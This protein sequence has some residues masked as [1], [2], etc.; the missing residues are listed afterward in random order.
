MWY[1]LPYLY[2]VQYNKVKYIPLFPKSSWRVP[3]EFLKSSQRVPKEFPQSSHRV[4]PCSKKERP[5]TLYHVHYVC[6]RV[7]TTF[8]RG[9]SCPN[10]VYSAT[11]VA[12]LRHLVSSSDQFFEGFALGGCIALVC[13]PY[14]IYSSWMFTKFHLQVIKSR[15]IFRIWGGHCL[16]WLMRSLRDGHST[17]RDWE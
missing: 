12:L 11:F 2:N 4:L 5:K 9:D 14:H 1:I 16:W 13:V 6:T 10:L 15:V 17:R 3:E 7:V 8:G